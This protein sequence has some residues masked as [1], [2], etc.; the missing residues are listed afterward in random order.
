MIEGLRVTVS[1]VEL[2]NLCK[3]R[4]IH[5]LERAEKYQQQ[6]VS[7]KESAIEGMNYTNGDPV[8]ALTDKCASHE[9]EAA[10]LAFIADHLM[11]TETYLLGKEDLVK[12]GITKSRY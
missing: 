10:E 7:M 9:A 2:R 3:D 4:V 1:G 6:I 8:R 12:L 5:H 11:M